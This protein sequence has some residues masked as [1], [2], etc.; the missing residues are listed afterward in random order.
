MVVKTTTIECDDSFNGKTLKVLGMGDA[1]DLIYIT[2]YD[3]EGEP[4]EGI[5]VDK[6]E[7]AEFASALS[8]AFSSPY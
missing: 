3:K 1:D 7:F 8:E 4:I 5:K 6:H 2:F